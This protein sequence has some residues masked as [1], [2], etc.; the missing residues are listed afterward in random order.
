MRATTLQH[1]IEGQT[2]NCHSCGH[3]HPIHMTVFGSIVLGSSYCSGEHT[4][5]QAILV[6]Y[7][8]AAITR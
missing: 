7:G 3:L 4:D 2:V 6:K 1:V 5:Y 8:R